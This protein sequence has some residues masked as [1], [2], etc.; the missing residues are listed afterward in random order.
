MGYYDTLLER[1][2]NNF[3]NQ[4]GVEPDHASDVMIRMRV[5]AAQLD[6]LCQNAEEVTRQAFPATATGEY[7]E[8]HAALRGLS[9]KEGSKAAGTVNFWRNTPAGYNISIPAG[10]VV[11]SSGAEAL[12]YVTVWDAVLPGTAVNVSVTVEAVEPGAKYNL[13]TGS[14]TVMVT[15][16]AGITRVTHDATCRGGTD[17]ESD[18][19][20]R[21]RLLES[22][23]LPAVGGSPGYYRAMAL[24][25]NEVGKAKVVPACRGGGTVDVVVYGGAGPLSQSKLGELQRLFQDKRDLGIDVLVRQAV[26]TPVTLELELAVEEGWDYETARESCQAALLAESQKLD[27]GEPWLLARMGRVIMDQPGVY[28]YRIKLPSADAYPL[29]DHLLVLGGVTVTPMEVM[30]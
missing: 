10:T 24:S 26:T 18:E 19:D 13:R 22:C 7:L 3:R 15:P 21:Q 9:R 27:I 6:L 14:I 8:R 30:V 25:Q 11:Q 28:N 12:R 29:E 16:P 5:L 2:S 4:T 1:M 23:R 20:L 17:S